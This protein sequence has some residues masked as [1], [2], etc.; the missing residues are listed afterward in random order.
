VQLPDR[1]WLIHIVAGTDFFA[2][3]MAYPTTNAGKGMIFFKKLQRFTVFGLIDQGNVA[4]DAYMGRASRL[5]G[6][7]AALADSKCPGDCLGV[8]FVN[9]L[10]FRQVLVI[11]IGQGDGTYLDALSTAGAFCQVYKTRLLMDGSREVSRNA[12]KI[13]EFGIG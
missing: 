5:A 10:A 2:G 9:C 3:M 4:L 6:G 7:R 8:L 11:F 13:L 12:F 1:Q